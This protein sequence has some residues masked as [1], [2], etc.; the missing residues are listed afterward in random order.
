MPI[1]ISGR[2]YYRTIEACRIVGIS[3]NTLFRWLREGTYTDV[4]SVDRRGWRLFTEDDVKRL[5][6]EANRVRHNDLR[7]RKETGEVRD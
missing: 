5:T 6:S 7:P 2:T 4:E 3:R 1:T